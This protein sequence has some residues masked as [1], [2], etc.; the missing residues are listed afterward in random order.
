MRDQS[1]WK[2]LLGLIF[3]SVV[4]FGG[5]GLFI[6]FDLGFDA[7][8]P[9]INSDDKILGI[10]TA[11]DWDANMNDS[12]GITINENKGGYL[13][14]SGS[15]A[16]V[17]RTIVYETTSYPD[18]E[19]I[20]YSIDSDSNSEIELRLLQSNNLD[21]SNADSITYNLNGSETGTIE[22]IPSVEKKYF[23][24]E[25][26]LLNGPEFYSLNT[27]YNDVTE[28][29]ESYIVNIMYYGTLITIVSFL[30]ILGL[31]AVNI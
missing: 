20:I 23:Q 17:Y 24:F 28:N 29:S 25:I 13:T 27:E 15:T 10:D 21:M 1:S 3:I 18:F 8:N 31:L 6:N 9:E 12:T 4:F 30:L 14:Q 26:F 22:E 16:G 7:V 2:G 5:L 19:S 11:E